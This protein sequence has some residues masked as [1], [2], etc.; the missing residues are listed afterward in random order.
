M[1]LTFHGAAQTV[2]GSMHLLEANGRRILLDCGLY[3]GRRAEAYERNSHFPFD[4]RS[5]DAVILSHA[6]IDHSGNLPTLVKQG[7]RGNILCTAATRDLAAIMLRDSADIQVSDARF[8]SKIRAKHGEGPVSPLYT[9]EDAEQTIT[10][11]VGYAYGRSFQPTRGVTATF[12]DAGH[13][14]GSAT[15][16]LEIT[17]K[18]RTVR[19]AFTGDLGRR[20]LTILRDPEPIVYADYLITESTYGNQPHEPLAAAEARMA[21]LIN[22]TWARKGHV[23]I[24]A[25]AVGRTQEVVYALHRHQLAGIIPS[26][27][28]YVDSPLAI[29]AT[30]IFRLH[31]ECFDQETVDFLC[32][33][34]DPFGFRRLRYVRSVEES[35]RLNHMEEPF[36][37][38]AASGMCES[39][40]V[41]HHLKHGIE[42]ERNAVLLV[43]F[44]AENTLGRRLADGHR[45][46]PIFGEQYQVRA[47]VE[48]INGFSAHADRDDL[49]WWIGQIGGL[50]R[51]F[52][53]H[54]IPQ[55]A[56]SLAA[57][58]RANGVPGA[59]VPV[60]ADTVSL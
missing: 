17:E 48:T 7:F 38:V 18:G 22:A 51:A 14:L 33:Y 26:L 5:I 58:L 32:R 13:I 43:S 2:T 30:E 59:I 9:P 47:H 55:A 15:T 44:Q 27:P 28:V 24:P 1:Q 29:D 23:I 50:K 41:L 10:R 35:K 60:A 49:L 36:V 12:Y 20:N 42:D 34:E 53:V 6:H 46:V 11:L 16:L 3:Q 39:G 54:G 31:P 56:E 4:P 57:A 25:F 37:V 21:R 19:L 8:A 45:Q 40:R 52:V